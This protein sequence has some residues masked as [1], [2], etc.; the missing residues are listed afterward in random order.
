VPFS[1]ALAAV[2]PSVA[3]QAVSS[4][5][6]V[7]ITIDGGGVLALPAAATGIGV[8]VENNGTISTLATDSARVIGLLALPNVTGTGRIKLADSAGLSAAADLS[9]QDVVIGST[10]TLTVSTTPSFTG[11]KKI[12]NE[13]T[14]DLGKVSK[15]GVKVVN[16]GT[17]RTTAV[18]DDLNTVLPDIDLSAVPETTPTALPNLLT[19]E[20]KITTPA[21][22]I[23]S[24]GAVTFTNAAAPV[25]GA[26]SSIKA[27]TISF[28]E[29]FSSPATD[30]TVTLD[31]AV[32]IASS[33]DIAFGGAAG[34][35]TL[36]KDTTI[37]NNEG[38]VVEVFSGA[39][40][41]KGA[42]AA[43][44]LTVSATSIET[45]GGVVTFD[46]TAEIDAGLTVTTGGVVFNGPVDF[47]GSLTLA[48]G[49]A[50][51]NGNVTFADNTAIE[52]T[53]AASIVT[54]GPGVYLGLPNTVGVPAV[55]AVYRSVIYNPGTALTETVVLTPTA[56]TA[57]SFTTG[58]TITQ[59]NSSGATGIT[60][61]GKATLPAGATYKVD[62]GSNAAST[63]TLDGA[64]T[65]LA[66]A[67]G[68]LVS[69]DEDK[70]NGVTT[71]SPSSK[72]TLT[73]DASNGASLA[74][75]GKVLLGNA[76]ITGGASGA[77]QAG[78]ASTTIVLEVGGITGT[79][80]SPVLKG[81]TNDSAVITLGTGAHVNGDAETLTVTNATIDI[82][83]NGAVAFPWVATNPARLVLKGGTDTKG[84]LKL[85][86][87]TDSTTNRFLT[88]SSH[89]VEISNTTASITFT[90]SGAA[91]GTIS[92]GA[93]VG[94]NDATITGQTSA[95]DVI[96]K[97]GATLAATGS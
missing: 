14:L 80:T 6:S 49:P 67:K 25:F 89:S 73:G 18:G 4:T 2:T 3:L 57:L 23:D 69:A 96:V 48:N 33:K 46:G 31:G 8:A 10:A 44:K 29:G 36:A 78:A 50:T 77:W 84:A 38:S 93:T 13:G 41:L 43:T 11:T 5:P 21:L 94:T 45:T 12:I 42:S 71:A 34:T 47:G 17:I 74:G 55:P 24:Q 97:A 52:M 92:G 66:L 65:E 85:G 16:R 54:L 75:A 82:A 90:T 58:R 86:S 40:V 83:T 62:L 61:K 56:G 51:F 37:S 39:G 72:L 95:N 26:G 9:V 28:D 7:P 1:S 79:G 19:V 68:Y 70:T 15:I 53:V 87:G 91:A 35:I 88:I 22:L 60:I 32:T 27:K 64:T 63:L 20:G 81:I 30:G 76:S 59:G